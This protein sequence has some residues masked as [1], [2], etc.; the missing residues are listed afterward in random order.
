[1]HSPQTRHPC[2]GKASA[3]P[4]PWREPELHPASPAY[5]RTRRSGTSGTEARCSPVVGG[6]TEGRQDV[7]GELSQ[8]RGGA[9]H[10]LSHAEAENAADSRVVT[11]R[12]W[13]EGQGRAGLSPGDTDSQ[14]MLIKIK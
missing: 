7:A 10:L 4:L 3:P 11:R 14:G 8:A 6:S 13:E 5:E 9:G 12:G 2:P 1:M